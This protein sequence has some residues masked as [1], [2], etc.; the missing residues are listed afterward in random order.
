MSGI[1][2]LIQKARRTRIE[3]A[4]ENNAAQL[5][6]HSNGASSASATQMQ[7]DEKD[8]R[9]ALVTTSKKPRFAT[10][11]IEEPPSKFNDA[12]QCLFDGS[13]VCI[14]FDLE[15][16]L[17]RPI[18]TILSLSPFASVSEIETSFRKFALQHHPDKL[19]GLPPKEV[20]HKTALFQFVGQAR[21][22][23]I[24]NHCSFEYFFS[25]NKI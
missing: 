17:R 18:H 2:D 14:P 20:K 16:F 6:A 4:L 23:W 21:E 19:F 9:P 25:S 10:L 7:P 8:S 5:V 13:K 1:S 11:N 3:R 24:K 22:F 15:A 12:K